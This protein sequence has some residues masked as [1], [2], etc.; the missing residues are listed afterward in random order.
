VVFL[1][2]AKHAADSPRNA[3]VNIVR[4]R[5]VLHNNVF[6]ILV[7][8]DAVEDLIFYHYPCE[9]LIAEGKVLWQDFN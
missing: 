8:I 2:L 6:K 3:H 5:A 4:L 9:E 1:S 7:H